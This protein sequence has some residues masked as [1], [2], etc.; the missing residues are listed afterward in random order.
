MTTIIIDTK[1][2][3]KDENLQTKVCENCNEHDLG[4]YESCGCDNPHTVVYEKCVVCN[5]LFEENSDS[6]VGCCSESCYENLQYDLCNTYL[7]EEDVVALYLHFKHKHEALM[8]LKLIERLNNKRL[9][10]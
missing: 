7:D 8:K 10:K 3:L 1:E 9:I 5:E 4:L 6:R 2:L